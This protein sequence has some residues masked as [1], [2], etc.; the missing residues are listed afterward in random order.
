[1][2]VDMSVIGLLVGGVAAGGVIGA[3]IAWRVKPQG[4]QSLLAAAEARENELRAQIDQ[5]R[6]GFEGLRNK[7]VESEKAKVQGETRVEEAEKRIAEQRSLLENAEAKLSKAF[8][9]LRS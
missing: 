3:V 2:S 4:D 1:M 8:G 6:V 5:N 9:A 7:L